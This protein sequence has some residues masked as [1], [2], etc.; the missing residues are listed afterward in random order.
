MGRGPLDSE[1]RGGCTARPPSGPGLTKTNRSSSSPIQCF[2]F[3]VFFPSFFLSYSRQQHARAACGLQPGGAGPQ[4]RRCSGELPEL[5][6]A[7][8]RAGAPCSGIA[9]LGATS[10]RQVRQPCEPTRGRGS[11][12]A[13]KLSA[14]EQL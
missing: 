6:A 4:E 1:A 9:A 11:R 8:R 14:S 5:E 7:A 10:L 2:S 13:G 3:T 12:G